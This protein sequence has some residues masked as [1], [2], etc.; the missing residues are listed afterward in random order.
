MKRAFLLF[1]LF[2]LLAACSDAPAVGE[3]FDGNVNDY[4]GV[5]MTVVEGTAY[6]GAV[7]VEV[8]NVTEEEID[9][10]NAADFGLQ[11]EQEGQWY[12]L[13]RKKSDYVNTAEALIYIK[14]EPRELTFEWGDIYGTLEPGHY[15]VTKRFF[16]CREP[17]NHLD[18]L[19]ASEFTL[20]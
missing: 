18:F 9:S 15:R 1:P 11:V 6:P 14:D 20:E 2:L 5:T 3:A 8:L 17:G 16:E 12:W 10:G 13:E 7:T 4:E 19:L